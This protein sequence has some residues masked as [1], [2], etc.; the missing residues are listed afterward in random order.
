M[1]EA[2]EPGGL[3]VAFDRAARFYDETRGLPAAV[4]AAQNGVLDAALPSDGWCLEIGV[5]TGR[6]AIPLAEAGHRMVGVDLSPPMLRR[7]RAKAPHAVP[8]L[9][10]DATRLPFPDATFDAAVAAHVFHLIP[11]WLTAITELLRVVRPGGRLLATRAGEGP[12]ESAI[13]SQFL[14]FSGQRT[15]AVGLV[16]LSQLDDQMRALGAEI[17]AL[18]PIAN[19]GYP[20]AE[21]LDRIEADRYSWTWPLDDALRRRAVAHTRDWFRDTYGDPHQLMVFTEPIRWH[22]Y[23]L[24]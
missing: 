24:R 9:L 21:Y 10:A 22:A 12:V 15:G 2:T 13:R 8:V 7:L 19:T 17:R 4:V 3:S 6:I 11:A 16:D 18:P 1:S 23:L 14:R 5:G 20:A